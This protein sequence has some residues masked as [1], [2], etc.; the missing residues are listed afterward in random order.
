MHLGG[1]TNMLVAIKALESSLKPNQVNDF[2]NNVAIGTSLVTLGALGAFLG[3]EGYEKF[4]K[5]K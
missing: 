5:K 4:F 1:N 3:Y 2:R